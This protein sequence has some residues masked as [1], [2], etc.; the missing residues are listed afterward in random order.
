MNASVA[1]GFSFRRNHTRGVIEAHAYA[2]EVT[3]LSEFVAS[4]ILEN[5]LSRGLVTLLSKPSPKASLRAILVGRLAA[6]L[7]GW[8]AGRLAGSGWPGC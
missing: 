4:F 7:V 3:H 8:L 1:V 2:D 5:R 6:G